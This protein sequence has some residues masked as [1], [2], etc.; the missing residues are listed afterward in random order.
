MHTYLH[1]HIPTCIHTYMHIHMQVA[2]YPRD[3]TSA[4]TDF[5][6]FSFSPVLGIT[7][8]NS[9]HIV[10]DSLLL[11]QVPN[12]FGFIK[13]IAKDVVRRWYI[14]SEL[15]GELNGAGVG[16][17]SV[18]AAVLMLVLVLVL[19]PFLVLLLVLLV[20]AAVLLLFLLCW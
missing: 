6:V 20:S 12:V 16:V 10:Q 13:G 2:E 19:G 7:S 15:V 9:K 5:C 4:L 14:C 8:A 17:A 3:F 18:G 11:G 1:T